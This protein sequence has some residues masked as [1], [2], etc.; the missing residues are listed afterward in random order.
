MDFHGNA[1]VLYGSQ[2]MTY[3]MHQLLHLGKSVRHWGPLWAHS[4]FPFE[5]GNGTLKEAVKASSGIAHQ[6]SRMLQIDTVVEQ[7]AELSTNQ[8]ALQYCASLTKTLTKK[9]ISIS[10]G[11]HFLGRG[12]PC[13][14]SNCGVKNAE[15]VSGSSTEYKRIFYNGSIL[16]KKAYAQ[17]KKTDCSVVQLVGGTFAIVEKILL[18]SGSGFVLVQP[19][20]CRMVKFPSVEMRHMVKVVSF[21]NYLEVLPLSSINT[22]CVFMELNSTFV[23]PLPSSYTL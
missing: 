4:A 11:V 16:T 20:K 8:K 9:D 17:G 22:V 15:L 14:V 3:N 13:T 18:N 10:K 7:C 23:S 1:E 5:A 2:C 21:C 19:V 6:I 12:S